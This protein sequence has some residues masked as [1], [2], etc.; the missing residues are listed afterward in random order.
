MSRKCSSCRV[1]RP[2]E[3]FSEF[4]NDYR[5]TCKNCATHRIGRLSKKDISEECVR[6][7]ERP[8]AALAPETSGAW[9]TASTG[10]GVS[11]DQHTGVDDIHSVVIKSIKITPLKHPEGFDAKLIDLLEMA[12][13]YQTDRVLH[14]IDAYR[15]KRWDADFIYAELIKLPTDEFE[16]RP[17]ASTGTGESNDE[18]TNQ[19]VCNY[20]KAH[21]LCAFYIHCYRKGFI[22]SDKLKEYFTYI[23]YHV[24]V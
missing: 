9:D 1:I 4:R 12:K 22:T 13:Q 10:T 20:R 16:A 11:K 3:C 8:S 24:G 19:A 18:D 23:G 5:K 17:S 21:D 15:K 14:C 6:F 7:V 2:V